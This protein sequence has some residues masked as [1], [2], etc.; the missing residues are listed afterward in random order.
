[1]FTT[2][3]D[4]PEWKSNSKNA[5]FRIVLEGRGIVKIIPDAT[6]LNENEYRKS[7]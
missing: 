3:K 4:T 5:N 6:V 2:V 1:M 7:L